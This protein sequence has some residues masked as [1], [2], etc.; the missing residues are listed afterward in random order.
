M[1]QGPEIADNS[2]HK[3]FEIT[4]DGV[5]AELVYRRRADRLILVHTEV[6]DELGGHGV[7]GALVQAAL[8]EAAAEGLTVVPICPFARSWLER[9][10]D[11]T[12]GVT[13]DWDTPES[14]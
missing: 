8:A 14:T 5:R 1:T 12:S 11:A 13:I 6:P 3:R 7:G 10:P 9:H 4:I 2:E